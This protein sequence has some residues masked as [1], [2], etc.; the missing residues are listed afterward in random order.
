MIMLVVCVMLQ[1]VNGFKKDFHSTV[2]LINFDNCDS[3]VQPEIRQGGSERSVYNLMDSYM[4][5][6]N[7]RECKSRDIVRG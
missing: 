5:D 7:I 4:S 6:S 1:Y 2:F 3:C